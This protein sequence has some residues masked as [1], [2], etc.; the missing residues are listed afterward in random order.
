[1]KVPMKVIIPIFL[2]LFLG[3]FLFKNQEPKVDF[4][5]EHTAILAAIDDEIQYLATRG[6]TTRSLSDSLITRISLLANRLKPV[7]IV[8]KSLGIEKK[9]SPERGILLNSLVSKKL[10]IQTYQKIFTTATFNS[11]FLEE[12]DLSNAPLDK[13]LLNQAFFKN[14]NL[15]NSSLVNANLFKAH[16]KNVNFREANLHIA[17]LREANLDGSNLTKS[18][19]KSAYLIDAKF[20]GTQMEGAILDDANLAGVNLADTSRGFGNNN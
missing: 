3:F 15:S 6:I 13:I 11:A 12:A 20:A 5:N 16:F 18:N 19:L 8:D 9:L 17:N 10:S 7:E 2:L 4:A 1:M 14:V